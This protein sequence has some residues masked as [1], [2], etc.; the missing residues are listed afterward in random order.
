MSYWKSEAEKLKT[1]CELL[2]SKPTSNEQLTT[3]YETQLSDI[4]RAKTLALSETRSLSAENQALKLRLV[5]HYNGSIKFN[6]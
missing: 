4:L 5:F 1:Q 2:R 3:Y 6:V